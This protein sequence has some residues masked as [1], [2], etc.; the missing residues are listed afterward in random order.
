[1]MS[2]HW[3]IVLARS[4][5]NSLVFGCDILSLGN[6]MTYHIYSAEL[7]PTTLLRNELPVDIL[8][9][10]DFFSSLESVEEPVDTLSTRLPSEP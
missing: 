5:N 7:T 10:S 8:F 1:M 4:E 3:S 9:L 6:I 2:P